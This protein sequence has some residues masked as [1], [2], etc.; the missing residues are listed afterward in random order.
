VALLARNAGIHDLLLATLPPIFT[1]S[2]SLG[3]S[4]VP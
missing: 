3:S 4:R 2:V 1:N